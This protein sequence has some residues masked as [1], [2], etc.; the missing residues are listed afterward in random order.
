MPHHCEVCVMEGGHCRSLRL[1]NLVW[2]VAYRDQS[3]DSVQMRMMFS[4]CH[5]LPVCWRIARTCASDAHLHYS[6]PL[7]ATCVQASRGGLTES[8]AARWVLVVA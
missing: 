7:I 8:P 3:R 4:S 6:L 2:L 5:M 1:S